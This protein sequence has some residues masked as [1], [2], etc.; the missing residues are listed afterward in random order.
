MFLRVPWVGI[1]TERLMDR[2]AD[3]AR[4]ADEVASIR[5]LSRAIL[6]RVGE[7]ADLLPLL[8]VEAFTEGWARR[9]DT[10]ISSVRGG[11]PRAE[12]AHTVGLLG[13]A[14]EALPRLVE[15]GQERLD[16]IRA[17]I[18][19]LS[20]VPHHLV[21]GQVARLQAEWWAQ[22]HALASAL[23]VEEPG[24]GWDVWRALA[25]YYLYH[26]NLRPPDVEAAVSSVKRIEKLLDQGFL[27]DVSRGELLEIG[28]IFDSL[29]PA[30]ATR[31]SATLTDGNWSRI[32]REL[33]GAR[34]GNLSISEETQLFA[35][36]TARLS[37]TEIW[38]IMRVED[39]GLDILAAAILHAPPPV[40]ID[41]AYRATLS[42]GEEDA[43]FAL[44]AALTTLTSLSD[45]DRQAG[46]AHL[47]E[48]G[49][50]ADL[51]H[52][53]DH[54][55]AE[56]QTAQEHR[57]PAGE[58]FKGIGGA[59]TGIW[60]GI[61]G[62]TFQALTDTHQWSQNWGDIGRL[63]EF[64]FDS[65]GDFLYQI[66]DIDT[67]E[68]NPAY[69]LGGLV[70]DIAAGVATAGVGTAAT[71][72]TALARLATALRRIDALTPDS[73]GRLRHF[74][75]TAIRATLKTRLDDLLSDLE[76][77]TGAITRRRNTASGDLGLAGGGFI[78]AAGTRVRPP[79]VPDSWRIDGTRTAGGTEYYDPSNRGNSV[80]VMQ[81]DPDSPY[82]GSQAPYVRWQRN[83]QP[84][85]LEG[86]PLSSAHAAAAHIPLRNFRFLPELFE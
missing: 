26:L 81:G 48:H 77:E 65:P 31:V 61:Y 57:H 60:D 79:G 44:A 83:G 86:R 41:L 72:G 5:R 28:A 29:D 67:L 1:D 23:A 53:A 82:P 7:H 49:T 22:L 33:D 39:K 42:L 36:L 52:A 38:R 84:L 8:E 62:L 35:S 34:G 55:Q 11:D 74:D 15:L 64:A 45:G 19:R 30:T 56:M 10:A 78:P 6:I 2:R 3:L 32:L 69:W 58:F 40:R 17:K 80:R 54:F 25:S 27:G 66:A 14:D 71:R 12:W 50:L 21:E 9:I 47:A 76:D 16:D 20:V 75:A 70:P 51:L 43:E 73:I 18:D 13:S 4:T 63:L 59:L 85:D 37:G 46:T 68:D 24:E